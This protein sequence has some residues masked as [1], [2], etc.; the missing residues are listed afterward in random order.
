[1]ADGV[2][3][4]EQLVLRKQLKMYRVLRKQGT[5]GPTCL[6]RCQGTKVQYYI[7]RHDVL[8]AILLQ[9]YLPFVIQGSS[10]NLFRS[11][12]NVWAALVEG[13]DP[14]RTVVAIGQRC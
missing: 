10:V 8:I 3:S 13:Q 2:R 1:M 9:W 14:H 11:S 4:Q 7:L 12:D 5:L 6:E